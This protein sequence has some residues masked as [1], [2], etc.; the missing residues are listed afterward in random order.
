M[1]AKNRVG[2]TSYSIVQ[3]ETPLGRGSFSSPSRRKTR[4]VKARQARLERFYSPCDVCGKP[5]LQLTNG[6]KHFCAECRRERELFF[7]RR[8]AA[9]RVVREAL[10]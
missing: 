1:V 7:Q 3:G 5:I 10:K 2:K 6:R 8:S 4:L 9:R